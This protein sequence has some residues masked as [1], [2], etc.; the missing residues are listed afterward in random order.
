MSLKDI[1]VIAV[2]DGGNDDLEKVAS[3]FPSIQTKVIEH[4][5]GPKA[6]NA[7]LDLAIGRYVW[8]WDADCYI[9][10][11]HAKR[12]LQEFEEVK[13]ADFVYS[14]FEM[15]DNQGEF[16]SEP[17]DAYSLQSGNFIS[18]M[19]PIKRE[20]APRWDESLEAGQD[21]DYWLTAVEDGC[22]GVFVEGSGFITDTYRTGLSSVKW[23]NE[24]RDNTIY[25]IRRKHGIR[26]REIGV[27]SQNY[28]A[29][30]IKL[31]KVLDADVI[32][33]TGPTPS[34]YKMVINLGY[35]FLSRFDGIKTDAVKVQYWIPGEIEG[36]CSP[37]AKY[38]TVKET[39][40]VAQNVLNYCGT[41]YEA[42]KLGELGIKAEV[43]PLP[44]EDSDLAKVSHALPDKF[45]VL[46]ASD[47][48]YSELLK[49]L[50]IDLPHIKFI[51][52]AGKVT[53]F[54]CFMSF[55]RFAA[56]DSAML[57]AHVNGRHVIS[58]VQAPYCGFIDPDQNWEKFKA[59][60]FDRIREVKEKPFNLEAQEYYLK[61]ADPTLFK[62]AIYAKLGS[63]LEVVA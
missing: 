50:A 47:K 51:Y 30:G 38:V 46:V 62:D 63:V 32:K 5:G 36:L 22:K 58:N 61:E 53:D 34:V 31:A 10:P 1:E 60:L 6:R 42:N 43:M 33:P 45:T 28:R 25:T 8:F 15:S 14:G 40:R 2:F 59:D 37:D 48:A 44:L 7:G 23:S 41:A 17:F 21:W 56:L 3:E 19:A 11:D 57:T 18:S 9:K 13:D 52:N 29:M 49:E 39:V 16:S 20:K 24:N 35:G 12:M 55:Y 54:S 27:F 4:G 26:D